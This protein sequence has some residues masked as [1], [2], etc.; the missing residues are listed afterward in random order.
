MPYSLASV[1][2]EPRRNGF[3]RPPSPT[4]NE[5][6]LI[7]PGRQIL[8]WSDTFVCGRD[9]RYNAFDKHALVDPLEDMR[10]AMKPDWSLHALPPATD[11][12][13]E[14]ED[15]I[16]V[17]HYETKEDFPSP[18]RIHQTLSNRK[19]PA[20]PPRKIPLSPRSTTTS[21]TVSSSG[22]SYGPDPISRNDSIEALGSPVEIDAEEDSIVATEDP[23]VIVQQDDQSIQQLV[24]Q[25]RALF[26]TES[27]T[28]SVDSHSRQMDSLQAPPVQDDSLRSTRKTKWLEESTPIVIS[29]S[30]QLAHTVHIAP[31]EYSSDVARGRHLLQKG[32]A[33]LSKDPSQA[34]A[35]MARAAQWSESSKVSQA[36][37][38]YHLAQ[39]HLRL[40]EY[41]PAMQALNLSFGLRQHHLGPYHVDTIDVLHL[42]GVTLWTVR[43]YANAR[44]FFFQVLAARQAV[45]G[46]QH[47]AVASVLHR[48]GQCF[49]TQGYRY[50]ARK[51][52]DQAIEIYQ[53]LGVQSENSSMRRILQDKKDLEAPKATMVE[54]KK[55]CA[56]WKRRSAEPNEG[57]KS[58]RLWP[59]RKQSI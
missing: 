40:C 25:R 37:A 12:V 46:M 14:E 22:S 29:R 31:D 7:I 41:A 58:C 18:S 16:Q 2:T 50:R 53:N 57:I 23:T 39:A 52:Y 44:R 56:L 17:V 21:L 45:F 19:V 8:D 30:T 3:R 27:F 4:N 1:R 15:P 32:R 11:D 33:I 42:M 54:S 35:W 28:H 6:A 38:L 36:T 48:L 10:K 47:P 34:A 9:C 20:S 43:D 51:Y 5:Q 26:D 24:T 49:A 55:E 59:S 13:E